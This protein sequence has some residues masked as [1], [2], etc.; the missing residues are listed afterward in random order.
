M[1]ISDKRRCYG[2]VTKATS[3][4][5]I[6]F[7]IAL[8]GKSTLMAQDFE[9][10]RDEMVESQLINRQIRLKVVLDAMRAIPR[11][12]F[13]PPD[14]QSSAYQDNPLPIGLDQTISQ[15][16]IV[17]FMTEQLNPVPGMKILEIGTGSGYQSAVLAHI[18]CEVYTIELLDELAES[19][20][21]DRKST[22]LNSSH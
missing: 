11:H 18:G 4:V 10:L 17:A 16:Y 14:M 19:A 5:F 21:K 22:R 20:K 7:F 3:L 15:P 13:V 2:I 6:L 8:S 9:K 12:L 1:I